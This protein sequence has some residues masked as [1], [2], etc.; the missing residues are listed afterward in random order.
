MDVSGPH[1]ADG[2]QM[3]WEG[4]QWLTKHDLF[5]WVILEFLMLR[6][7]LIEKWCRED[8]H[9]EIRRRLIHVRVI[10]TRGTNL[11]VERLDDVEHISSSP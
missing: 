9:M 10:L 1:V 4:D 6:W 11:M 3:M 2:H 8:L 5:L 7:L